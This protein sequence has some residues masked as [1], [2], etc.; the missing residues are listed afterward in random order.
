MDT[1]QYWDTKRRSIAITVAPAHLL[2]GRSF[3]TPA[4]TC[5]LRRPLGS[6]DE[7]H[8]NSNR[9]PG[10]SCS[11]SGRSRSAAWWMAKEAEF[12]LVGQALGS[13]PPEMPSF[14]TLLLHIG[15]SLPPT[16][17]PSQAPT[18]KCSLCLLC[19]VDKAAPQ[20]GRC[21]EEPTGEQWRAGW[22]QRPPQARLPALSSHGPGGP[23]CPSSIQ[24]GCACLWTESRPGPSSG[25]T[26]RSPGLRDPESQ[27][28]LEAKLEDSY[29][30]IWACKGKP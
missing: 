27:C 29:P 18:L 4:Q 12:H 7:E 5:I 30:W 15:I 17:C 1:H 8:P 9:T 6:W 22:P 2:Q 25:A 20:A 13:D 23:G 28:P 19:G 3:C 26:L 16:R 11:P 24:L 10:N 21:P 14:P